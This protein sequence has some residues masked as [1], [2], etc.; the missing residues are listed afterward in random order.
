MHELSQKCPSKI[1]HLYQQDIFPTSYT[2]NR[3]LTHVYVSQV[4]HAVYV[5]VI[6]EYYPPFSSRKKNGRG[7]L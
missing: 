7:H 5:L 4:F 2:L 3:L 1:M 6:N